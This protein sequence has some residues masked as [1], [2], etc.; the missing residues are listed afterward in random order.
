MGSFR[1]RWAAA[2]LV[3]ATLLSPASA[4]E[5]AP[6]ADGQDATSPVFRTG[7]NVVRVDVIVTDKNGQP[8]ADLKASDFQITENNQPQTID[9]F[10][11][12]K[13]DGGIAESLT[14]PPRAIRTDADEELEASRDDVRLFAIFLDDYHTRRGAS[15][16]VR[17]PIAKFIQTE[18]GPSDMLGVM[19]PLQAVSSVL[20]T[21]DHNRIIG[22]LNTFVGRKGDYTPK[23]AMEAQYANYSAEEVERIRNQVS[24]SAIEGL[25][26]HMGSLKVGRKAL[27]LVS[28]GFSSTLPPQLRDPIATLPGLANPSAG[29]ANAGRNDPAE[30]RRTFFSDSTLQLSLREIYSAANRNNVAIY[31]VDPR[32]LPVSEFDLSQPGISNEVDRQY[33]NATMDTLRSLAEETDGRAIVNRNDLATGM[34]QIVRDTSAYYLL[35]YNSNQAPSDGKFHEIKVKVNRPG[36]Q[37]RARRGY[38][39]LTAADIARAETPKAEPP[40]AIENALASIGVPAAAR[41]V[42]RTWIGTSRGADGKTKVTLVWEPVQGTAGVRDERAESP[43]RVMVTAVAPDG[44]PYFRGR[45]PEAAPAP[46]APPAPGRVTFDAN[47][48]RVQLRLSVEGAASQVLDTETREIAVPDRTGDTVLGTPRLF[49]ARTGRDYQQIKADPDAVPVAAREFSRADRLLIRV[50]VYGAGGTAPTLSVHLL[51]R[52]GQPMSELQAEAAGAPDIQQIDMPLAALA[53]G[54]YLLEIKA[55]DHQELV[56]FRV[57]S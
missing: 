25:I 18:L 11:L 14:G 16:S 9:T 22:A 48:G 37:V 36:I 38:W 39:A 15:V 47:P 44:S 55:G 32:G 23:N 13:L 20:M 28:E 52:S 45:V 41:N 7:I 54:E 8:V 43:A 56:G 53:P 40:K 46:N 35:G 42:I 12:V 51:N 17:E 31:T 10:K 30:D 27:I 6:P 21:R 19:Y 57:T 1:W 3:L 34:K 4:Q 33:L 29:D 50:P 26:T 49:R 5:P 2:G 24:M